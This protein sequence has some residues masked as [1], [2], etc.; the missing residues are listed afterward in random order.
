MINYNNVI[1]IFRHVKLQCSIICMFLLYV[2]WVGYVLRIICMFL[3]L[4]LSGLYVKDFRTYNDVL[5]SI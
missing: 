4:F 2:S 5:R 1:Y 3:L